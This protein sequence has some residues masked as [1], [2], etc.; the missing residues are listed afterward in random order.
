MSTDLLERFSQAVSSA[1]SVYTKFALDYSPQKT[2]TVYCF[3][4]GN[5]DIKYYGFRVKNSLFCEVKHY[6]CLGRDIVEKVHEM[7][8]NKN[9][10]TSARQAC[11]IDM[12]YSNSTSSNYL[13]V[14]PCYSIEN[15][16][17][18]NQ[19]LIEILRSEFNMADNHP[20]Y[21]KTLKI[22]EDLKNQF[23]KELAYLNAWL[24]CQYDY[25]VQNNIK[26]RLCID[27]VLK[28]HM[29]SIIRHDLTGIKDFPDL[30]K[31]ESL[32]ILFPD[33]PIMDEDTLALTLKGFEGQD[34]G[35]IFRGKFEL[36]FFVQFVNRVKEKLCSKNST[37]FTERHKCT[38]NVEPANA[39]SALTQYAD[40][41]ECLIKFIASI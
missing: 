27:E 8:S 6:V 31:K 22:Y 21:I 34:C 36:S 38:L 14:T 4:E 1:T 41:P 3:V 7:I 37:I 18:S 16:Y 20:D 30:Q 17:T 10:Y 25:R 40:T 39:I 9:E 5:E 33:A 35:K 19:A 26:T 24:A 13:Y 29:R 28:T 11:F 32:E 12:D 23:H 15:L 2:N